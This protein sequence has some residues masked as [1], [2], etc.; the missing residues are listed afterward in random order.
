MNRYYKYY[1]NNS[2]KVVFLRVFLQFT[3]PILKRNKWIIWY[4][5]F[6]NYSKSKNI[7]KLCDIFYSEIHSHSPKQRRK[8]IIILFDESYVLKTK[9]NELVNSNGDVFSL[10]LEREHIKNAY[11]TKTKTEIKIAWEFGR[12]LWI[13]NRIVKCKRFGNKFSGSTYDDIITDVE[14]WLLIVGRKVSGYDYPMENALRLINSIFIYTLLSNNSEN[15]SKR[16]DTKLL[17]SI[18]KLFLDVVLGIELSQQP[19]NHYHTE[20]FAIK[21]AS[22][23]FNSKKIYRIYGF[24]N[25]LIGNNILD[26][27]LCDGGNIEGSVGYN[28]FMVELVLAELL[29]FNNEWLK[30]FELENTD[31]QKVCKIINFYFDF[32]LPLKSNL[33]D[34]DDSRLFPISEYKSDQCTKSIIE[35][36]ICRLNLMDCLKKP[37]SKIKVANEFGLVKISHEDFSTSIFLRLFSDSFYGKGGHARDDSLSLWISYNNELIIGSLG[38]P[39]YSGDIPKLKRYKNSNAHSRPELANFKIASLVGAWRLISNTK[40]EYSVFEDDFGN[41]EILA[42]HRDDD[43]NISISRKLLVSLI[44]EKLE[45]KIID[46]KN[47]GSTPNIFVSN[48]HVLTGSRAIS[49]NLNL[50]ISEKIG[51]DFEDDIQAKIKP[52][53]YYSKFNKSNNGKTITLSKTDKC[54]VIKQQISWRISIE[55]P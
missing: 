11:D 43:S 12:G 33:G 48:L 35:K 38:T 55:K 34:C 54:A 8:N 46:E 24:F 50:E 39:C 42:S 44:K 26:Q 5:G 9:E 2:F 25:K 40:N 31:K 49:E 13:L 51:I 21:L 47:N 27:F 7:E 45:I 36:L 17:S 22:E 28:R 15:F 53:K 41:V 20:L 3:A 6:L 19:G 23:F 52:V 32:V 37:K 10:I 4:I 16:T 1:L 29:I 30:Q 18:H 14:Y